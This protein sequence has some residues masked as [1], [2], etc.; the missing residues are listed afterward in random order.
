M[1]ERPVILYKIYLREWQYLQIFQSQSRVKSRH[2]KQTPLISMGVNFW[3]ILSFCAF[4]R[5]CSKQNPVPSFKHGFLSQNW[6]IESRAVCSMHVLRFQQSDQCLAL[7]KLRS[8]LQNKHVILQIKSR[9]LFKQQDEYLWT[10][11]N[12]LHSSV[13]NDCSSTKLSSSFQVAHVP[14]K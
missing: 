5:Q 14:M 3:N 10:Q 13:I 8:Q 9:Q 11:W 1:H 6:R 4:E 7:P 12:S 2:L